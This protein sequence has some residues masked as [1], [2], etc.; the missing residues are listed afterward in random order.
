MNDQASGLRQWSQRLQ[1][2]QRETA[3]AAQPEATL[4][5]AGLSLPERPPARLA[6]LPLPAG[7][8]GWRPLP[9]RLAASPS[10]APETPFW[11]L[12]LSA[13]DT[14]RA[15]ALGRALRA[16]R[17]DRMP[18]C[19]LLLAEERVPAGLA[20]A[21]ERQLGVALIAEPQRWLAALRS[22]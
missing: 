14:R 15:A 18:G 21:A 19:V 5:V 11:A 8:G 20:G 12:W 6:E 10:V 16:L 7:H 3:P 9:L 4:I 22:G 13:A 2:G 17:Q 1:G